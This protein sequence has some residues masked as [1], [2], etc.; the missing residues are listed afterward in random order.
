MTKS[1]GPYLLKTARCILADASRAFPGSKKEF[2]RDFERLSRCLDSQGTEL[3]TIQLPSISKHFDK[4]LESGHWLGTSLP[5]T[6]R[7]GPNS[8][9]PRLFW[10]LYSRI[11]EDNGVLRS[12]PDITAILYLRTILNFAKKYKGDCN[13]SRTYKTVQDF[14]RLED[15]L[16]TPTLLW[17]EREIDLHRADICDYRSYRYN[18]SDGE[19]YDLFGDNIC[20][21]PLGKLLDVGQQVADL[22][23]TELGPF[24][25]LEW[26]PKHGPGAVSDLRRGQYKYNVPNWSKRLST[27]FPL[28]DFAFANYSS[29][30]DWVAFGDTQILNEVE[31]YSK[32]I[33]APK[34]QKGPRLIA[35]EPVA[36]QWCQQI[37]W[38]FFDNRYQD[39]LMG[40]FVHF[41]DQSFNQEAARRASRTGASW[42]VDLS[43]ASDCVTLRLVERVF[44]RNTTLLRAFHSSRT[45]YVRQR[46]DKT[47]PEYWELRKFSTQGSACTFPL[48]SH[49]FLCLCIAA[50][51][52]ERNLKCTSKNVRSLEGQIYVYGDDIII[53]RDAG[54]AL[55]TLLSYFNFKVNRSK[56]F[57]KGIFR[58]SCGS[59][60]VGGHCVTPAYILREYDAKKPE[61]VVS[62]IEASNNFHRKGFWVTARW[63][64]KTVQQDFNFPVVGLSSGYP[65]FKSF[66]SGLFLNNPLTRNNP[67]L[68]Q[69]D[70]KVHSIENRCIKTSEEGWGPLLQY[71]TERPDPD[72]IWES[73]AVVKRSLRIKKRWVPISSLRA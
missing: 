8:S 26:T 42:T 44:R 68:H 31:H 33:K 36:H 1:Y 71:F 70:V 48:E 62:T 61:T 25:P 73:G 35:S 12:K 30:A 23:A 60:N 16:P 22:L 69:D 50:V 34:T 63:L 40:R 28:E 45:R 6:R 15:S 66:V 14:Y 59:E 37:I 19:R 65:S 58:E 43:S 39:S 56:T 49:I 57:E 18:S 4:C 67:D 20:P 7:R 24:D 3:F 64:H 5:L 21:R 11:F 47:C 13:E 46:I 32:L 9:I 38:N 17:A 51:L 10:G 29:W 55:H 54:K 27:V 52:Y 72:K 2:V 41:R 53:P